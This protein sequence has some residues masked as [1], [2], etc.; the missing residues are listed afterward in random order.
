MDLEWVIQ[1]LE[2]ENTFWGTRLPEYT[3]ISFDVTPDEY[4]SFAER[5]LAIGDE[6]HLINALTHSKRALDS[7]VE[8]L[9]LGFGLRAK[10]KREHLGI[11]AKLELIKNIGIVAPRILNK[12][13]RSRNLIEHEFA[14]PSK[15]EVEDFVD[16]VTLFLAATKIFITEFPKEAEFMD[17]MGDE[18]TFGITVK[19]VDEG[20]LVEAWTKEPDM[21]RTFAVGINDPDYPRLVKAYLKAYFG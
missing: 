6:H 21:H 1:T 2:D 19:V 8:V 20:V 15:Q 16:V 18:S 17:D 9:L 7:Q 12:F 13:N 5:D 3:E 4:L 11:P 14:A 10:A